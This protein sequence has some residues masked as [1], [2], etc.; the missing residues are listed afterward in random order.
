MGRKREEKKKK[1]GAKEFL[2]KSFPSSIY[3][4]CL[5]CN[6]LPVEKKTDMC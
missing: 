4:L 2:E 3:L 6:M 1:K 5:I